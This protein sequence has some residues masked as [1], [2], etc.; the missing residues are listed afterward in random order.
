VLAVELNDPGRG[1]P[2]LD[3][4]ETTKS[5]GAKEDRQAGHWKHRPPT[6]AAGRPLG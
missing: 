3:R 5:I 4:S 6:I 2:D 1:I